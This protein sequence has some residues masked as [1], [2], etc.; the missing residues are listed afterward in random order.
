MAAMV[1]FAADDTTALRAPG[2]NLGPAQRGDGDFIPVLWDPVHLLA[3]E[4]LHRTWDAVHDRVRDALTVVM[5]LGGTDRKQLREEELAAF[6][7]ILAKAVCA[8]VRMSPGRRTVFLQAIASAIYYRLRLHGFT[9]TRAFWAFLGER[10]NDYTAT[11][12]VSRDTKPLIT[13]IDHFLCHFGLG[14]SENFD[15]VYGLY[16]FLSPLLGGAAQ[17]LKERDVEA[18]GATAPAP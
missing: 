2:R 4:F 17:V 14:G 3:A 6:Y 11:V 10:D 9:D 8:V 12:R 7:F 1:S 15:V 16:R 18:W 13:L 5:E